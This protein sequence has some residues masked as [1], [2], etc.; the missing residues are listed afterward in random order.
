MRNLAARASGYLPAS[1][2]FFLQRSWHPFPPRPEQIHYL[3]VPN[4][5][6]TDALTLQWRIPATLQIYK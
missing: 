1:S 6:I 4:N 5:I 2:H 3:E